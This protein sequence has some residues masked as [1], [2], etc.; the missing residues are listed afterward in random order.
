MGGGNAAS[1][2]L[3]SPWTS[4]PSSWPGVS[5]PH[6]GTQYAVNPYNDQVDYSPQFQSRIGGGRRKTNKKRKNIRGGGFTPVVFSQ[7]GADVT[8][9]YRTLTGHAPGPGPLPYQDHFSKSNGDTLG[10]VKVHGY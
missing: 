8:N 6:A 1:S 9:A 7:M 2:M 4:Q 3:S 10:Y 5:G